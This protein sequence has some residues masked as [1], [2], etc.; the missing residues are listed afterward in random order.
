M[1][2]A[3]AYLE[4]D[5][6]VAWSYRTSF[7]MQYLALPFGL[8]GTRFL[9]NLVGP[10]DALSQYGGDY[11]AFALLG[12]A[13]QAL[14]YPSVTVF[15]GAVREAQALG[16]F[17]AILMTR[18]PASVAVVS[19]GLYSM[20]QVLLQPM[21][22][23][24]LVGFVL[25]APLA[26]AR[27]PIAVL[28]LALILVGFAGIG[29][30]SAA[31]TIAFKQTEPFTVVLL[32]LAALLGG[33]LYPVEML[34]AALQP[35]SEFIPVRHGVEALRGVFIEGARVEHLGWHLSMLGVFAL[36]FPLGLVAVERAIQWAR[37]RGTIGQY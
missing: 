24:P 21:V 31:F 25:G 35:L 27:A 32:P 26:W 36:S 17:E 11:F 8:L 16:T 9:A 23:I 13:V 18:T 5:F 37:D 2:A 7:F 6:R 1:S 30:C 15:R 10:R 29:L 28:V 22:I 4:R 33:V 12:T 19:S 20:L 14:L 3:V 34:P